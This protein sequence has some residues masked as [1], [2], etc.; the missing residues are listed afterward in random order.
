MNARYVLALDQGTTSS[1]AILFDQDGKIAYKAQ[2]EFPQIFPHPS[3][4]EH[5]PFD[6]LSS[7]LNAARDVLAA[8]GAGAGSVAAIGITNQ[9]ET[10]ILWDRETGKP[11]Y[12][13]IVWQCR[14]TA[15]LCEELKA[16]GTEGYIR[17]ATGLLADAYFSG[18]K[19]K[20]ML[21]HVP[22]ARRLA[23]EGRLC[24]GTVDSWLLWNLTGGAV[25]A[26]DYSNASRTLLYNIHTLQWDDTLCRRLGIPK[27][28]LPKVYPSSH[29][30]GK[31]A[32]DVAGMECLAGVPIGGMAGDQHAALFGQACF[33]PGQAKNT[34]G[35]GCFLLMNTGEKPVASQNNLLTTI[36]WGAG[37]KV[38]Y[39]LE[40]SV[41]NAGSVIKWLRDELGLIK[42]APECDM[43][44]ESVP[45]TQGVYIVPAFTGLGAPYWDMYA[46]GIITGLTRGCTRAHLARAVLE[47]IAYQV[48]DL[49]CAMEED[50]TIPLCELRVDGG[51][52]VSDILLSF[53]ADLLR[54]PVVRPQD[55]ETTARGASYL[56][57][58]AVGFFRD[59]GQLKK[60][61]EKECEFLP[62][63]PQEGAQK[64]YRG[65]QAAVEKARK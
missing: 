17:E 13:A 1:R 49:V 51:A 58:L 14:R 39:A 47:S 4:V 41:F 25:H 23:E 28:I 50:A 32:Q 60:I 61:W 44:A 42:S 40:G 2:Y 64:L 29:I 34:Y 59:E 21:D 48:K 24:F 5:N 12:N 56:A 38:Q 27:E 63:R 53:Q 6:I 45:D 54:I 16:D 62:Q 30:F 15:G 9:R 57:G 65:W 55:V 8:A 18:T 31:V 37:G 36:A 19:I 11:V 20:W 43:L 7:Q 26:T 10:T 3:W 35:T 52:S 46:R 33:A 22:T